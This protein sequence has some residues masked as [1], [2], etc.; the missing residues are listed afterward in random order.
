MEPLGAFASVVTIV[1]LIRPTAKFV[2]SLRGITSD[3]GHVAKEIHTMA[4]RIQGS[5]HS[6]D[7]ALEELKGHSSTLEKMQH[8]PSKVLQ[9]IIDNKSMDIIVSGTESI[10]K[11]MRDIARD[12]SDTKK[13]FKIL[14]KIDWILRNK[15]EVESLFPEMQLVASC[16]SLVCP[17]I[18][19]E[20]SQYILNKSSGEVAQCLKQEMKS[21]RRQLEMVE[22]QY[23]SLMK[24]Q[25]SGMNAE[26]DFEAVA[27][28]L[29]RLAQSVR[30]TG[31]A[32]QPKGGSTGR[33]SSVSEEILLSPPP[34]TVHNGDGGSEVPRRASRDSSGRSATSRS[35]AAPSQLSRTNSDFHPKRRHNL[36]VPREAPSEVSRPSSSS[37][38]SS[39]QHSAPRSPP[40]QT[41]DMPPTPQSPDSLEVSKPLRIDTSS[42]GSES[43][44]GTVQAIQGYIINPQDDWKANPVTNAKIDHLGSVNCISVKTANHFHLDIQKLNPDEPSHT[45]GGRHEVMMPGPVIGKVTGVGWSKTGRKK[46]LPVEFLVKDCYHGSKQVNVVFGMIFANDLGATGGGR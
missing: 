39:R 33:R 17:I 44:G 29:L 46:I 4:I 19:L 3:D 32:P 30:R 27:K 7:V 9:Y 11:Q 1:G 26:S 38:E 35:S 37:R 22:R 43:R 18:R 15:M 13:R 28:P 23:H 20:I 24:E 10:A 34:S 6:I 42:R 8:A 12:L 31:T 41:P 21:L 14:K 40:P 2:R 5:A 25:R 45:H 36:S 16:L